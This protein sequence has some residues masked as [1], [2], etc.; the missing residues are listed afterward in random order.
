MTSRVGSEAPIHHC[1]LEEGEKPRQ[2]AHSP[3]SL[4]NWEGKREERKADNPSKAG[5][6]EGLPVTPETFHH[7]PLPQQRLPLLKVPH[8]PSVWAKSLNTWAWGGEAYDSQTTTNGKGN[9]HPH[10]RWKD[11]KYRRHL[12]LV[13]LY[14]KQTLWLL[15]SA[16]LW[17]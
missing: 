7:H 16:Y 5:E 9:S 11:I 2:W 17:V 3:S 12:I 1:A 14:W 4:R 8:P 13:N 6:K 10:T 15:Y